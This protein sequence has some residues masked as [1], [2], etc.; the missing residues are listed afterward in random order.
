MSGSLQ[1]WLSQ[2]NPLDPTNLLNPQTGNTFGG[3]T[4]S[5][6]NAYSPTLPEMLAQK[7]FVSPVSIYTSTPVV[8]NMTN[9]ANTYSSIMDNVNAQ[10]NLTASQQTSQ[11]Q[12][13]LA[14]SQAQLA[15]LTKYGLTDTT[16]LKKDATGRYVPAMAQVGNTPEDVMKTLTG[17]TSA[18]KWQDVPY[19]G[20]NYSTVTPAT[21]YKVQY[22]Q[23]GQ[24]Q[25][26]PMT[27]TDT[28]VQTL[29]DIQTS[30]DE[31]RKTFDS[32]MQQIL[33]GTFPLTAA[34]QAQVDD[35]AKQYSTLIEDQKRINTN[36]VAS[37]EQLG[38]SQGINRYAP[39][40][41]ISKVTEATDW[42]LKQINKLTSEMNSS[43]AKMKQGF[44]TDNYKMVSEAYKSFQD[45]SNAKTDVIDKIYKAI[46]SEKQA[47]QEWKYKV[48]QDTLKNK[49]ESDKFTWQQKMDLLKSKDIDGQVIEQGGNNILIDKKTGK[50]I[51]N[52]GPK[53]AS[54]SIT[55]A[56]KRS[57]LY[58][59]FNLANEVLAK[60]S[61]IASATGIPGPRAF[62]P[63]SS[64]QY[65]KN[66]INQLKNYLSLENR[67]KL[68]G[69]GAIS[70]YE[71]RMLASASSA[72][73][74]NLSNEDMTKE[75][76]KIR[77]VM[78]ASVGLPVDVKITNPLDGKSKVGPISRQAL[79]DA[80]A[81]GYLIEYR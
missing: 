52:Y 16:Q 60:P 15:A 45:S 1:S 54:S 17:E 5:S 32:Q 42:G 24:T 26:I 79:N 47:T 77:D 41:Q 23:T 13:Q 7:S 31:A 49:L 48:E 62:I 57:E 35:L 63:G 74:F 46:S 22:D 29:K 21:G 58:D 34:Q 78:Q 38:I 9:Y 53:D 39:N 59:I 81:Q 14:D 18:P 71:S 70:D 37:T 75:I 33:G 64:V 55:T 66:Q 56:A 12:T 67:Q 8:K 69:Q 30:A 68:K 50:V 28:Y 25:Q 76:T 72:L 36:Y 10:K 43:I 3:Q 61:D 27:S 40:M 80:I 2:P 73:G 4:T 6:M 44:M 11:L 65:T 19:Q 20:V 51:A